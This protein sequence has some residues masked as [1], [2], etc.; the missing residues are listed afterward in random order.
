MVLMLWV[1]FLFKHCWTKSIWFLLC[2]V[3]IQNHPSFCFFNHCFFQLWNTLGSLRTRSPCQF[4]RHLGALVSISR[5]H[6]ELFGQDSGFSDHMCC[7]F[8]WRLL[9]IAQI[10]VFDPNICTCW[11]HLHTVHIWIGETKNWNQ[12][13]TLTCVTNFEMS[14]LYLWPKWHNK[15]QSMISGTTSN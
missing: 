12:E 11:P 1:T 2:T 14:I 3:Q 5:V 10:H 4:Q 15:Y 13:M 9:R 7:R 6:I 8:T